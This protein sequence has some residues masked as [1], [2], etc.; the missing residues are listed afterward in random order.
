VI[1]MFLIDESGMEL[2]EYATAAALVTL[3]AIAAFQL[4]GGNIGTRI[5]EL[6]TEIT[7]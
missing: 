6:A 4:L 7:G 2:S 3:A 5:S 1:K